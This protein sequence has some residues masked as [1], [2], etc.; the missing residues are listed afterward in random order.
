[1]FFHNFKYRL[2]TVFH[3]KE[4]VFWIL[5]FP[6]LL[7]TCF[8]AA[9][10]N[11]TE[12]TE[13]FSTINVAIV[14]DDNAQSE[15]IKEVFNSMSVDENEDG[16]LSIT[17]CDINNAKSLLNKED[18]TGIIQFTENSPEIIVNEDGI[19]ESI[20]KAIVDKYVQ[21]ADI[22]ANIGQKNPEA[23]A[24]VIDSIYNEVEYITTNNLSDGNMDMFTDY[25]Y[26]LIAMTCLFGS[27]SGQSCAE[28]L[29]ANISAQGMRKSLTPANRLVLILSDFSATYLLQIVANAILVCYLNFVL[30]INLGANFWL[31]MLTVATGSLIGV[32]MGIFIGSIPKISSTI[33]LTIIS[34]STLFSSFLSGLMVGGIKYNIEE[35]IPIVNK[36]NP[37]T[38]ITDALYSLNVYDTYERF[39]VCIISLV[40]Y[41]VIFCV[42]SYLMTRRESYASL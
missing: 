7:G 39:T 38:I 1:M 17:Y 8:Y 5:I 35:Y 30:K 33:K 15:S 28:K 42:A 10:S 22:L 31:I 36:L 2:K 12:S 29:K 40:A 14:L 3:A 34:A 21:S 25:Y 9:F 11:V 16:L 13:N 19:N 18:I 41:C 6:I 24:N 20:L 37:A 27:L 32:S 26:S 4:E 23:L